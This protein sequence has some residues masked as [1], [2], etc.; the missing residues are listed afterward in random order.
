[1]W[2]GETVLSQVKELHMLDLRTF[3]DITIEMNMSEKKTEYLIFKV[4][5]KSHYKHGR[6]G[7]ESHF[8]SDI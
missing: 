8:P 2:K 5:G 1:M 7:S 3:I 6:K 4:N